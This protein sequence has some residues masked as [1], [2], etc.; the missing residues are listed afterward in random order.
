MTGVLPFTIRIGLGNRLTPCY[1]TGR[2]SQ[3]VL[4]LDSYIWPL[5]RARLAHMMLSK[6]GPVL[7]LVASV[8]IRKHELLFSSIVPCICLVESHV[9]HVLIK[10]GNAWINRPCFRSAI[11]L[12][13]HHLSLLLASMFLTILILSCIVKLFFTVCFA[14]Y[15]VSGDASCCLPSLCTYALSYRRACNPK[16]QLPYGLPCLYSSEGHSIPAL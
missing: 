13:L 16:S 5:I 1:Q 7:S 4:P 12:H 15:F 9:K 6:I 2:Q 11:A 14:V 8:L 10:G 3:L